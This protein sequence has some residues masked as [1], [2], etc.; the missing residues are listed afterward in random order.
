VATAFIHTLRRYP[1]QETTVD[2]LEM[3]LEHKQRWQISYWDA[4]I[5]AAARL[6]GC[7]LLLTEDLLHGQDFDGVAVE[8]PFL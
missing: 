5:V 2:L 7:K 8:N 4:A 6:L 3:A 1:V